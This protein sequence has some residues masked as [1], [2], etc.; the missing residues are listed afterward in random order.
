M[1]LTTQRLDEYLTVRLSD[2]TAMNDS[3]KGISSVSSVSGLQCVQHNEALNLS[4]GFTKLI[5]CYLLFYNSD[6]IHKKIR[7]RFTN[8]LAGY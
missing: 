1:D 6:K 4:D 7:E 2:P 5:F 8:C 3:P